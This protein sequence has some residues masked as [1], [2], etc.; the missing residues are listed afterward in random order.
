MFK[1]LKDV[2]EETKIPQQPDTAPSINKEG[3]GEP[4]ISFVKFLEE[5]P[6]NFLWKPVFGKRRLVCTTEYKLIDKKNKK[7]Y[8]YEIYS[9]VYMRKL[10]LRN[11]PFLTDHECKYLLAVHDRWYLDWMLDIQRINQTKKQEMRQ[12]YI[13]IYCKE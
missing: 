4:V 13:D 1:F 12:Q 8:L 2:W 10:T 3:V 7:V 6:E 11:I 5:Q 9:G